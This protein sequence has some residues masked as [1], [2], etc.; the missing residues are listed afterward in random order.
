[1][2]DVELDELVVMRGVRNREGTATPVGKE[3]IQ[4]LARLVANRSTAALSFGD[5]EV[6]YENLSALAVHNAIDSACLYSSDGE[7]FASFG[8]AAT[9]EPLLQ[10]APYRFG[11]GSLMVRESVRLSGER[12]GELTI[13]AN[14]TNL[15]ERT[16]HYLLILSLVS[17]GVALFI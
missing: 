10:G 3:E 14:L 6:A 4:V 16:R 13:S 7:V 1:M 8:K 12:L 9:C 17:F 11:R 2:P 15:E 5:R